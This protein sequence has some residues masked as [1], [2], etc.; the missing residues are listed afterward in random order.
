MAVRAQVLGRAGLR[1]RRGASVLRRAPL[2]PTAITLGFVAVA[3]L[4]DFLAPHSPYET[5]LPSRL[6][7][8]FWME[9]GSLSHPLGMDPV[10]RDILS[11]IILGA[12]VSLVAALGAIFVGGGIG[13]ALGLISGYYGRWMDAVI[14]RATDAMLSLPVLLLALLFATAL[15]PSF[16]NLI[17]VL[18]LVMW[19]RFARLVRGEVLSWKEKDFVALARVAGVSSFNIILRHIFPNV[20]NSLVVLATLQVGWVIIVEASLSFLGAGIPPPTPSW[21]AMVADGRS[22]IQS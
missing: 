7:P 20:V 9:G 16:T 13:T 4:G 2:L 17:I 15:G 14:M 8:P 6:M 1:V 3:V 22:Y 18:A 19:A 10:G 12:R 11:R 5:T 21:G